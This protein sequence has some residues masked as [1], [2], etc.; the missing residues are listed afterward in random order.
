MKIKKK[1]LWLIIILIIIVVLFYFFYFVGAYT[2]DAYVRANWVEISPRI[3]GYVDKIVAK[4]N[5]FVKKGD[6]LFILDRYPYQLKV[7]KLQ[8]QLDVAIAQREVYKDNAT[9]LK[10]KLNA[11]SDEL[12]IMDIEAKRYESLSKVHAES[13]QKYQEILV[14]FNETKYKYEDIS[15]QLVQNKDMFTEQNKQIELI[16]AELNLA[17]Y[18]YA[19]TIIKAPFDGYVT[20]MY[21]MRGQFLQQG[22]A[23]FGIAQTQDCWI[24]ANFKECWVGEVKPGQEVW[25][26][27]DLYPLR[28]FRGKV[29]SITNAVSRLNTPGMIL[30][31]IKPTIDWVRLQYRFTVIVKI[32]DLPKDMHLRMGADARVFIWL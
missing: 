3:D 25:I 11:V 21:L 4:N 26:S 1:Y 22:E 14:E 29:A 13:V 17:K 9:S 15:Q 23:I 6:T 10:K 18:N 16:N 28:F 30:P 31:Y 24:E 27:S 7:N 5:Q 2:S 32:M 20:N 19:N 8:A 12:K